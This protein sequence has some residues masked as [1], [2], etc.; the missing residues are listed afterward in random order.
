MLAHCL[1]L[2][3]NWPTFFGVG[4]TFNIWSRCDPVST[5]PKWRHSASYFSQQVVDEAND[6]CNPPP[7]SIDPSHPTASSE[8]DRSLAIVDVLEVP[9]NISIALHVSHNLLFVHALQRVV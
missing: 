3:Y 9:K 5:V 2:L 7:G 8:L 6:E 1:I 4:W